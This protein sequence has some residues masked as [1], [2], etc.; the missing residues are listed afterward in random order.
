MKD[1]GLHVDWH[2]HSTWSDGRGP[3]AAVVRQARQR[4]VMAGIADHALSDN[5]RLCTQEQLDGYRADLARYP[6][7]RGV[8]ISVGDL[9]LV[10]CSG[11]K[12][13][14]NPGAQPPLTGMGVPPVP[15]EAVGADGQMVPA[16]ETP[17]PAAFAVAEGCDPNVSLDGFDYVIA[18]LHSVYISE[19]RVHATRYHNYRAGLYPG[20]KRSLERYQRRAF[21]DTWLRALDATARRWPV[22]ILGHF[23]LLPELASDAAE[24]DPLPDPEPDVT[25][26]AWLDE[27]IRRCVARGVAIEL[28]SKSRVP[29]ELFVRR[30]LERGSR[31]SLGSD[32]HQRNRA[33]DGS[34]GRQLAARLRI[35][36]DRF[37]SVDDVLARRPRAE[38]A[39]AG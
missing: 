20:Y 8:E 27:V 11:Q 30:A 38:E 39:A 12:S 4:G 36:R 3:V 7:L 13:K 33:G 31:F 1:D 26:Q 29:H 5:R 21:F 17:V 28:N 15:S 34:Y 32:A 25:A 2:C 6:V 9:G 22:T 16:D 35:P 18:S 14:A 23:C 19:G 37:L 24:Y 10:A